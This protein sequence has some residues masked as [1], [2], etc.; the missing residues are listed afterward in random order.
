MG[1]RI[2]AATPSSRVVTVS[3]QISWRSALLNAK[4]RSR[5]P[6][7]ANLREDVQVS[8]ETGVGEWSCHTG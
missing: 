2:R 3:V 8:P 7:A 1:A 4:V 6:L 5:V